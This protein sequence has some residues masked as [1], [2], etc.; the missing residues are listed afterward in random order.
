MCSIQKAE[1]IYHAAIYVRLSKEDSDVS[2]AGKKESNSISNQKSL[3]RDFLKDKK[4]IKIVSERIDDGYSGSN[5]ERPQ[6]KLMMEEIRKG[7]VDCVVVKDLSRFGREYIDSGKYIERLFPALGV[8]FIAIN[9]KIDSLTDGRDDIVVPFKNLM[10]DAYCRDISIKIRSHLE[11]KR[12]NGDYIGAFTP[13]GYLKDEQDK[14]RI[15]PD[16]YA[17]GIVKEI[18]RMKLSGMS[19]TAIAN[20]LNDHGILSPMEYKHSLGINIQDNF[21]TH[22]QAEWSAMSVRRILENE[23]YV[24]TLVQGKHTTPNH[25]VKKL[26]NKPKEEWVCIKKNHTPIIEERDFALVQRLLGM[27][28]RTSPYEEE[29]YVLSGIAICGDCG[30]AMVKRDVPAGGKVYSYYIC[31]KNNA[32]KACKTHRI[33]REKLESLV[34]KILQTHIEHILNIK[35]ILQ[36][37]SVVPFQELDIKELENR[38]EVKEQE[39]LR[40]KEMRNLLYED[41]KEGVVSKEDY[42]E[43]YNGYNEKRKKAEEAV[44]TIQREIEDILESKTEK[45]QW[46][47]Y[48]TKHQ[49]IKQLTRTAVVEL[50]DSVKVFDKKHIEVNFQFDDCYMALLEQ[51]KRSG[52]DIYLADMET[53]EAKAERKEVL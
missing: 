18:F 22:G 3:I 25:K 29:V 9:D 30:A 40:C 10:N 53:K 43:L 38:K 2:N 32:T 24:G 16:T 49:N 50:V 28:T 20:Y 23:V 46:L 6:F 51:I 36:Y 31:S 26:V 41:L 27:D 44:R 19:Q 52:C 45:Y 42:T 39:I 12:R 8:R 35:R 47:D 37:A 13:Y 1:R 5:F 48:F 7:I 34:L 14:N 11:V 17:A 33:P 21:K 15:V 4:D